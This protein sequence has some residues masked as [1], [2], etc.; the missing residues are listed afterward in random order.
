MIEKFPNFDNFVYYLIF[1]MSKI[2]WN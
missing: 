1:N 2:S